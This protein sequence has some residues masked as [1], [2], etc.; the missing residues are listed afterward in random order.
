M[1]DLIAKINKLYG[2]KI[3]SFEKVAKGALSD[4]YTLIQDNNKYF[5][6]KYRFD[7]KERIEEVHLS[8]KYFLD[9]G[10]PVVFPII[11]KEGETYFFFDNAY[12]ALFP[13]VTNK[14]FERGTLSKKAIV[15]LG[16]M[17]GRIHLL[18]KKSKLPIND[19]FKEW[20]KEKALQKISNIEKEINK[21][22]TLT[23]FDHLA[24]KNLKM[25]KDLINENLLTFVDINLANDHLTHGDYL[26]HNVFF[27]KNDQVSEVFDFEKTDYSPRMYELFRS[28]MLTFFN[29]KFAK[30]NIDNAKLFLNT[31]LNIYPT[32]RDE[33][34]K[35]LKLYYLKS[36][37]GI[38][39][40]SEHFLNNNSRVD[41][42]LKTD[43]MR[44]K[45]LSNH[46]LEFESRLL[47]EI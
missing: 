19:F 35:G 15:S 6:K 26:D 42:F 46:Y 39:I 30:E 7:N 43:N 38:W 17:L 2:L 20:N 37:H 44:I 8:K 33:L 3:Q 32:S 28:L 27:D 40:E 41:E 5:L 4:N 12:Y 1:K 31:Y 14:Q 13:F 23:K 22:T 11:N 21:K 24:I 9:G 45:Y 29:D 47:N 10:I 36:I 25:K 34:S 18:G 16:E